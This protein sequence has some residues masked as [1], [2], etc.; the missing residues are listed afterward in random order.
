MLAAFSMPLLSSLLYSLEAGFEHQHGRG[1]TVLEHHL[2]DVM[3]CEN[4]LQLRG[5]LSVSKET[6]L[7]SPLPV[8]GLFYLYF[9]IR[10]AAISLS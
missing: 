4:A 8:L 6:F 1:F 9:R 10:M 7:V 3:S 2:A 5:K